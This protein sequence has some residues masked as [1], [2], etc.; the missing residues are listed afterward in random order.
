MISSYG[1]VI[2][3][4]NVSLSS[5][6]SH[7]SGLRPETSYKLY[8]TSH[9]VTT[10]KTTTQNFR[11]QK[12]LGYLLLWTGMSCLMWSSSS[13][14]RSRDLCNI[15]SLFPNFGEYNFIYSTSIIYSLRY[16]YNSFIITFTNH[17]KCVLNHICCISHYSTLPR[18][19]VILSRSLINS[20]NIIFRSYNAYQRL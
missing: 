8:V 7:I 3:S 4:L 16:S 2:S 19:W 14:S 18:S 9:C 11:M 12:T 5:L 13:S 10:S 1:H 20:N 15:T 6:R 17:I